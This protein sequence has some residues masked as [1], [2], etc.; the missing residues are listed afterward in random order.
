MT[1]PQS[2]TIFGMGLIGGSLALALKASDRKIRIVGV[3]S[4]EIL[5]RA[6]GLGVIDDGNPEESELFI[7]ATPVGKILDLLGQIAF[8]QALVTDVGSTKAAICHKAEE[9]GLQFIGGH[10]MAGSERSGLEAATAD[11]FQDTHF[12]LCPVSTTPAYAV[13]LM[14][15]VARAIGAIPYTIK[16]DDH[17]RLVAQISHLPQLISTVL[18]EQTFDNYRFAGPGLKSMIRLAS[19]PTHVWRDIFRTSRF[20]PQEVQSF[21]DRLKETL[22]SLDED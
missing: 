20:L 21:V 16:P 15:S 18:A 19:S 12:F 2:I 14:E 3:D 5:G 17:D 4:P 9:H 1:L 13:D 7:L 6:R 10:P 22:N 11:L 8:G